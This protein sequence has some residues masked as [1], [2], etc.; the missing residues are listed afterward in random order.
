[1]P[2]LRGGGGRLSAPSERKARRRASLVLDRRAKHG[3]AIPMHPMKICAVLFFLGLS[4]LRGQPVT[5][6]E[7]LQAAIK[8][9]LEVQK[10]VRTRF[11]PL[12]IAMDAMVSASFPEFSRASA[13]LSDQA[14]TELVERAGKFEFECEEDESKASFLWERA[15]YAAKLGREAARVRDEQELAAYLE[16]APAVVEAKVR[17]LSQVLQAGQAA[18]KL[19]PHVTAALLQQRMAGLLTLELFS[20][21][22]KHSLSR[23]SSVA[24]PASGSPTALRQYI[25]MIRNLDR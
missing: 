4:V 14:F 24:D 20:I 7:K 16:T 3:I 1:M 2:S 11:L 13:P 8:A 12:F 6:I 15:A 5:T 18:G 25:A 22:K 17:S 23:F 21:M 19:E 10:Q 9:D